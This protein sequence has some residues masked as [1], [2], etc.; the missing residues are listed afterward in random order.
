MCTLFQDRNSRRYKY[1]FNP[2]S[3]YMNYVS[4]YPQKFLL[5]SF[6]NKDLRHS[7][8]DQIGTPRQEIKQAD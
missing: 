7:K 6:S 3:H 1:I 2:H 8:A 4:I 5:G